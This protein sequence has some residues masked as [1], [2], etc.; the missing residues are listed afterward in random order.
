MANKITFGTLK[1]KI[2]AGAIEL[3]SDLFGSTTKWADIV[4][5][6]EQGKRSLPKVVEVT[7]KITPEI[8]KFFNL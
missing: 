3:Q 4:T 1:N 6:N 5:I 2:E 8:T 7:G